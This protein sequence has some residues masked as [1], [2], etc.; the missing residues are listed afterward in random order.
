[1]LTCLKRDLRFTVR[2]K[3]FVKRSGTGAKEYGTEYS[4][5]C[6]I[7]S[8]MEVITDLVGA[9]V[10]SSIRLYLDGTVPV[11]EFDTVTLDNKAYDVK[12]ISRVYDKGKLS[13]VVL[14]L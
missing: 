7:E 3:P 8:G 13:L 14:Y 5:K 4:A 2:I 12:N 6:H 1:M 10:V 11:T 9:E